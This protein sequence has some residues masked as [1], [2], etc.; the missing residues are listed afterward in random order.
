MNATMRFLR[1]QS[2]TFRNESLFPAEYD[3]AVEELLEIYID[4]IPYAVTMRSPGDDLNLAAGF[5]FSEGIVDSWSDFL[6]IE[7]C[8]SAGNQSRVLI[9]LK[10]ARSSNAEPGSSNKPYVS[11]SSCGLCGKE[12]SSDVFVDLRPVPAQDRIYLSDIW[13]LKSAYD[14]KQE[15]FKITG[16]THSASIFDRGQNVLA[17]AEDI[18]RHNALDKAIGRLLR[19]DKLQDAYLAIVSSRLSFEMVQKAGRAGLQIISG[20]SAPTSMAVSMAEELN[21]TLIGFL[22]DKSLTIYTH[23]ERIITDHS[24]AKN[25]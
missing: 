10:Q 19:E 23:P 6:S 7:H 14:H 5:C 22:R 4:D 3:L 2:S 12:R 20:L 25:F 18:G 11:K 1:H 13:L 17:F 21:I 15:L 16:A 9:R 24:A 8:P